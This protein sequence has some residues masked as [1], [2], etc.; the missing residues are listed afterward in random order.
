M[1][2]PLAIALTVT[3]IAFLLY[4]TVA[5]LSVM[6]V[7]DLP[8]EWMYANYDEPDVIAW[9][10]SFFPMDIAFSYFGLKAVGAA[11]RG[12][13]VWRSY[14]IVSL[15]LTMAAGGM[16]VSYWALLKEFDPAWFLPNL[17]LV[18]WPLFFM[19]DLLTGE[20]A[21]PS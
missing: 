4:W 2:R 21:S 3:D 10:W 17:A 20:I 12:D 15:T 1:K 6:N 14:A 16:A 7:I 19:R 18:V 9:N 8:A 11:R 5:A 13:P